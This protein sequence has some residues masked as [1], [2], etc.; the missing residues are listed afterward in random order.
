MLWLEKMNLNMLRLIL[1]ICSVS[2]SQPEDRFM[3]QEWN[4][5]HLHPN[6]LLVDILD[7]IMGTLHFGNIQ[8]Q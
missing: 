3:A 7:R 8:L 1:H 2:L 5:T 4:D 6:V